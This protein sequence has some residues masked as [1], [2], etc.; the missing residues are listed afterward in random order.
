MWRILLGVLVL[1][2]GACGLEGPPPASGELGVGGSVVASLP[3]AR[4]G[5]GDRPVPSVAVY[6]IL[7]QQGGAVQVSAVSAGLQLRANLR[8]VLL[9]SRGV[10]QAVSVARDR[11]G[12]PSQ[13]YA[14]PLGLS[15]QVFPDVGVRLNF[16]GGANQVFYLRVENFATEPDTV[17]V[18]AASFLPDPNGEPG[19]PLQ[20]LP[21]GI[22][23]GAIEFVGEADFYRLQSGSGPY[24]CFDPGILDLVAKISAGTTPANPVRLDRVVRGVNLNDLDF[25]PTL[26]V[27]QERTQSMAGFNDMEARWS[28][29]YTLTLS[30]IPCP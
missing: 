30:P 18:Q 26:L 19:G 12:L 15:P 9:D 3:A 24:L 7:L 10:V 11:F 27:V 1:V 25:T 13:A 4:V 29:R 28:G 6:R 16:R 5:P 17:N 2:L 23:R 14:F 22:T 20:T 8:L 21:S